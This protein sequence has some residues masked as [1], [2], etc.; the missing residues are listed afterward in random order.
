M[1]DEN[2]LHLDQGVRR[3]GLHAYQGAVYLEETTET[4]HCFRVLSYSHLYHSDFFQKFAK[5]DQSS[6]KLEFYKLNKTQKKWY[7]ERGCELTKVPAPKGGMVLWDSRTVHDNCKPVYGRPHNDRWRFVIFVSMTPAIWATP[8][9]LTRK[10]EAYEQLLITTHWSSQGIKTF[11]PY[12]AKKERSVT[13]D[14]LPDIARTKE[15]CLLFGL[16][17]YNYKDGQPNGPLAPTWI[18]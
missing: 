1:P 12:G 16:E 11:K 9:D 4:D 10:T 13:I 8:E 2:W 6:R 5:A 3:Q 17:S 15:A 18:S 7:N 14:A